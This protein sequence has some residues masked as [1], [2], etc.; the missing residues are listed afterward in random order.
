MVD[1]MNVRYTHGQGPNVLATSEVQG[2]LGV[3][4]GPCLLRSHP[5]S[6]ILFTRG[7]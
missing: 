6:V 2:Q 5:S 1:S 4:V 3:P 7:S